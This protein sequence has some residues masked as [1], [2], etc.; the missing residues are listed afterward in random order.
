MIK[1]PSCGT[2]NEPGSR[3]CFQCGSDIRSVAPEGSEPTQERATTGMP[4]STLS[5]GF[6]PPPGSPTGGFPAATPPPGFPSSATPPP[7]FPPPQY[8]NPPGGYDPARQGWAPPSYMSP[9][10]QP[11]RRRWLWITL[12]LILG[13]IILCIATFSLAGSSDTV[14][15]FLTSVSEYSTEEAGN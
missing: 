4:E 5:G 2:M 8:P 13:C 3:F 9:P 14:S 1:C 6:P 10:E 15:D 11:K 7:G 12:G